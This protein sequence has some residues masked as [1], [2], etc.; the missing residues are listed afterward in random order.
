MLC[1]SASA[2]REDASF[3]PPGGES[4]A[5]VQARVAAWC[6]EQRDGDGTVVAVNESWRLGARAGGLPDDL[7]GASYLDACDAAGDDP[8]A[9]QA[10]AS[11][12]GVLDEIARRAADRWGDTSYVLAAKLPALRPAVCEEIVTKFARQNGILGAAIFIPGADFPV[13]TLNQIRMVLRLAA[14]H[15]E[16]LA[17][18]RAVLHV[19]TDFTT[20][21]LTL[22]E[23]VARAQEQGIEA[24]FFAENFLLRIEYGLPPF[25]SLIRVTREE[26][27]V[28]ARGVE[29]YLERVDQARALALAE[30]AGELAD[31]AFK[32]SAKGTRVTV[33]AGPVEGLYRLEVTDQGP[34]M[35]AVERAFAE[36]LGAHEL[37]ALPGGLR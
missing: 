3:A 16:E 5:A 7:V 37:G 20:G 1:C 11:L 13:L 29:R 6:E 34:G 21:D 2:W 35:A 10:A 9:R 26:P 25:R 19:H 12:R 31:N 22:D 24:I 4:L 27:S 33:S 28:L 32:F 15:G 36:T 23:I 14:A 18:V 17:R 8:Y 30:A